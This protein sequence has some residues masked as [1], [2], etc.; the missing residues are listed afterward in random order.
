MGLLIKAFTFDRNTLKGTTAESADSAL[1]H[2]EKAVAGGTFSKVESNIITALGNFLGLLARTDK[3]TVVTALGRTF[4]ALSERN[5]EDAWRWLITRSLWRYVVPNGTG[6][7][8]NATASQLKVS[9]SFFRTMLSLMVELSSLP[10][11]RRFLYYD[12]LCSLLDADENWADSA[13]SLFAKLLLLRQQG[14]SSPEAR[15]K[16]LDSLED[17]YG[18]G[19]DNMNGLLRKAFG[20]TGLF[21]YRM[22]RDAE[23]GIAVH[24]R[25]DDVLQ[26]RVRFILDNPADWKPSTGESWG[27]FLALHGNDLPIE[28]TK[29]PPKA[30]VVTPPQKDIADAALE[31]EKAFKDAGLVVASGMVSRFIAGLLAKRFVILTGLSGSGKTKLAQAVAT[32]FTRPQ[33]RVAGSVHSR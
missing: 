32:W 33:V 4:V 10:G 15:P 7:P 11:D 27:D 31:A 5:R 21:E 19:R 30:V 25:L 8:L 18:I 1:E 14:F 2:M 23:V 28:V 3:G 29:K 20:Q 24:Q 9:F 12:E 13:A 17:K 6:S 26:R 16:L 22:G